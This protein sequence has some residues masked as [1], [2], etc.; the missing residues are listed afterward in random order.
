MRVGVY[1]DF[2]YRREGTTVYADEAFSLFAAALA[3]YFERVVLIGREDGA[4][5]HHP[6]ALPP[7]VDFVGLPHYPALSEVGTAARAAAKSLSRFWSALREL[8]A[9]WLLGPHPLALAFAALS[10]VRRRRVVLGTRQD[11]P[12]YVRSRHP[13]RRS[14]HA[15]ALLFELAWRALARSLPVVVVGPELARKYRRAPRLLSS[16]VSL[17]PADAVAASADAAGRSY[18]GELRMLSVGRVDPEKNPLLLADVLARLHARD[19]R[20]RLVVCGSGTMEG[21]LARRLEELGLASA[22]ELHGY[23]PFGRLAPYYRGNHVFVHVS[24]TEGFPQ[25]ILE[26][27][28]AGLPVVA[29]DVGGVGEVVGDAALLVQPGDADAAADAAAR[30]AGDAALRRRCVEAGLRCASRHTLEAESRRV[31]DFLGGVRQ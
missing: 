14:L 3:D 18:D 12:A 25:V 4:S 10:A 5:A 19:P 16:F 11:F 13:R 20:W 24:W 23:V 27:F 1:S 15:A 28:A 22:S 7:S 9:V 30:L 29:T 26:A 31:A 21:A 17:V 2:S 8:D 6:Y